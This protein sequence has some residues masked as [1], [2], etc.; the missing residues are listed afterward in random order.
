MKALKPERTAEQ[1]FEDGMA[2]RRR[3][4]GEEY[5]AK[6]AARVRPHNQE[7]I[8]H[9]VRIGWGEIW[10]RPGFDF[11]TRR[12][13]VMGTMVALGAYE[14]FVMHLRAALEDGFSLDDVNE[15]LMQQAVYIGAPRVNHAYH[16]LDK[17]IDELLAKGVKINGYKEA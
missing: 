8:D 13:L 15:L 9:I 14:E 17:T 3:I 7:F 5:V 12:I 16:L 10:T 6:S 2:V 11:R 1:N 4:L